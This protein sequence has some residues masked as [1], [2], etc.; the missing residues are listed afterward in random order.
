MIV[1]V[2]PPV[3]TTFVSSHEPYVDMQLNVEHPPF[4]R[5]G[6]Y[7][8]MVLGAGAFTLAKSKDISLSVALYIEPTHAQAELALFKGLSALELRTVSLDPCGFNFK[9]NTQCKFSP[10]TFFNGLFSGQKFDQA[11]R[12]QI[13]QPMSPQVLREALSY[14]LQPILAEQVDLDQAKML[15]LAFEAMFDDLSAELQPGD[16]LLFS[17]TNICEYSFSLSVNGDFNPIFSSSTRSVIDHPE[18]QMAFFQVFSQDTEVGDGNLR[19]RFTDRAP[20][21]WATQDLKAHLDLLDNHWNTLDW[22]ASADWLQFSLLDKSASTLRLAG[23]T[24]MKSSSGLLW[25]HRLADVALYVDWDLYDDAIP[26]KIE[27]RILYLVEEKQKLGHSMGF[28]FTIGRDMKA[29]D[30]TQ[31]LLDQMML[32]WAKDWRFGNPQL[33]A[34]AKTAFRTLFPLQLREG[35]RLMLL[36]DEDN[37]LVL[38]LNGEP[39]NMI[40]Y[41][42]RMLWSSLLKALVKEDHLIKST[43]HRQDLLRTFVDPAQLPPLPPFHGM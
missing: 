14:Q 18:L 33:V 23:S 7:E 10:T 4:I 27:D 32:L 26:A 16:E 40:T 35:D 29:F 28:E 31:P 22:A 1:P 19:D 38:F 41:A 24:S 3:F 30:L 36:C 8:L 25:S 12:I 42:S 34:Q 17:A 20:L 43:R 9:D 11:V 2:E 21:L 37:R 39:W 15:Q 6:Q 13:E 5:A